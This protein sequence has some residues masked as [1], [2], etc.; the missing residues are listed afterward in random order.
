[1]LIKKKLELTR[2]KVLCVNSVL[3]V[4]FFKIHNMV[5]EEWVGRCWMVAHLTSSS[6]CHIWHHLFPAFPVAFPLFSSLLFPLMAGAVRG[7]CSGDI[8][9]SHFTR[10]LPSISPWIN[11][12]HFSTP[13][14]PHTQQALHLVAAVLNTDVGVKK[15][16]NKAFTVILWT[17]ANDH[18]LVNPHV[19]SPS[20]F[21]SE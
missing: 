21:L 4:D 12:N 18:T 6:R 2:P 15:A 13:P 3:L 7:S 20:I 11:I 16:S 8:I 19:C 9:M 17:S 1:M 10:V 5:M 14:T